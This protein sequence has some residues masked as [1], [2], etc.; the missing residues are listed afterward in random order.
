MFPSSFL[1][2]PTPTLVP[3][4]TPTST[5]ATNMTTHPEHQS[6]L[7]LGAFMLLH[8]STY[9]QYVPVIHFSLMKVKNGSDLTNLVKNFPIEYVE[10]YVLLFPKSTE[11]LIQLKYVTVEVPVY[12][13]LIWMLI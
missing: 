5:P 11:I 12:D 13:L 6:R 3:A 9:H 8:M 10:K 1:F 4:Y 7:Q 2:L